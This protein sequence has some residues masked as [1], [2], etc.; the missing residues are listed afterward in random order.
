MSAA[1]SQDTDFAALRASL[2]SRFEAELREQR[3]IDAA[4]RESMLARM[5]EALQQQ[6]QSNA[7]DASAG[8]VRAEVTEAIQMLSQHGLLDSSGGEEVERAFTQVYSVFENDAVNRALEFA[9]ISR[10]EGEEAARAWLALNAA[11]AS[12]A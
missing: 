8:H 11:P 9:R 4:S 12:T 6:G 10:E 5:D 7:G 1:S 3:D 2:L